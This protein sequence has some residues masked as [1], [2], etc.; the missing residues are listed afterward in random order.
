LLLNSDMKNFKMWYLIP[1]DVA[2]DGRNS[3]PCFLIEDIKMTDVAKVWLVLHEIL[4]LIS[5]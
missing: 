5:G 4:R 2:Q 3:W 1:T